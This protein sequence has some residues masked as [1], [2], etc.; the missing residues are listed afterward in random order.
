MSVTAIWKRPF[1]YIY[2]VGL[3]G[4]VLAGT[5]NGLGSILYYTALSRLDAGLGQMLYSLYPLFVA[6]WLLL[7][8]QTITRLTIFRL[9]L[10]LPAVILLLQ[11]Q[12]GAIDIPGALMMIAAAVLYALHLIINQRVLFEVPAPTVTLYTLLGM[13]ATVGIAYAL[14]DQTIPSAQVAWWPVLAMALITF[15]SRFTL[16]V[17]IKK[18][19]GLQTALLGLSEIFLTVFLSVIF[20]HEKLS[21]LQWIGGGLLAF[22][23]FLVG[24]DKIPHQ[25]RTSTGWLSWLNPPTIPVNE[26]PWNS[27]P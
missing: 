5:V 4:C 11:N 25:K 12:K 8:R 14:F 20:L 16:F 22:S 23:L 13:A 7:D 10:S 15:G 27:Q 17:G 19:G 9:S 26:Y 21:L 1:F 6:F 24:F 18:L 3:I 2:P